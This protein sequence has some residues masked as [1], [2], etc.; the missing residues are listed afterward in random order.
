MTIK[1][2]G[3]FNPSQL[4]QKTNSPTDSTPR[5]NPNPQ[6]PANVPTNQQPPRQTPPK[7]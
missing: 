1:K 5:Q 6:Q 2:T 3:G 7:K 4:P